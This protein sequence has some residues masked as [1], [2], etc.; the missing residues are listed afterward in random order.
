MPSSPTQLE[1][2]NNVIR[3]NWRKCESNV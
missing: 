2:G 3:S 1:A